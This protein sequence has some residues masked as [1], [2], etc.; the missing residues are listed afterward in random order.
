M[1][2]S[3]QLNYHTSRLTIGRP[4]RQSEYVESLGQFSHCCIAGLLWRSL[5]L[6]NTDRH[7]KV[8]PPDLHALR[9]SWQDQ[10]RPAEHPCVL[11]V[12]FFEL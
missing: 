6:V 2:F 10:D 1:G 4:S 3:L 8:Q 12:V 11:G 7:T 9:P 5:R